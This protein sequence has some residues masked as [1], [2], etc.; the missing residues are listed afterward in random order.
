MNATCGESQL[1]PQLAD[2]LIGCFTWPE[3][4]PEGWRLH[5][6]HS[7]CGETV[8]QVFESGSAHPTFGRQDCEFDLFRTWAEGLRLN[9]VSTKV[10]ICYCDVISRRSHR[11]L[12]HLQSLCQEP[13]EHKALKAMKVLMMIDCQHLTALDLSTTQTQQRSTPLLQLTGCTKRCRSRWH[14]AALPAADQKG[15][16]QPSS[17][18]S[19]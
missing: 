6:T 8:G 18:W 9:C 14:L 13:Q 10:G 5:S 19:S 12:A 7:E 15:I 16:G 3:E 1:S 2:C 17:A 4:P 11:S